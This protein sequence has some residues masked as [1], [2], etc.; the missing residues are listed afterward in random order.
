MRGGV[1]LDS[2]TGGT[3]VLTAVDSTLCVRFGPVRTEPQEMALLRI[4]IGCGEKAIE[5]FQ[6]NENMKDRQLLADLE[7]VIAR[8]RSELAVLLAEADKRAD[9]TPS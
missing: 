8:S 3:G 1:R 4:L 5:A 9:Q 6:A 7:S 2:S